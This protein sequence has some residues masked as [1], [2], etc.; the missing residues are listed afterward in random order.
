M[1]EVLTETRRTTALRNN[2]GLK[3]DADLR[4]AFPA[5]FNTRRSV[6]VSEDYKLYRSDKI[7]D[8]MADNGMVLVEVGQERIGW[9]R[10][11]QPHTQIHTMRFRDPRFLDRKHVGVGD[12]IPELLIKNSHDGRCLFSAMAALY[13]LV[14]S[15]GLV[16]PSVSLGAIKRRHYGEA[17]DF[18]KAREILAEM[19]QAVAQVSGIITSWEELTLTDRQQIAFAKRM[20]EVKMPSGARRAPEWMKPQQLLEHRRDSDA[21]ARDGTRSLWKTFNVLQEA[22]TNATINQPSPEGRARSIRP[23]T[24]VVDNVGMNARLWTTAEAYADNLAK[25]PQ[26]VAA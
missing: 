21:P 11:R 17:N 5:I 10:V 20:M 2:S 24:G 16:V 19:P 25:K 6:N 26:K 1:T 9:S 23:I 14:C 7:I 18:E 12:S 22:L 13:R 15:N 4:R 8:I 3:I